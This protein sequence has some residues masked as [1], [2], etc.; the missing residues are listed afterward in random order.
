LYHCVVISRRTRW[1]REKCILLSFLK[2][3]TDLTVKKEEV[4]AEMK[5]Q[6]VVNIENMSVKDSS[7]GRRSTNTFVVTFRLPTLP[8]H[9]IV[10]YMRVPVNLYIESP[11]LFQVPKIWLWQQS[12]QGD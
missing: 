7:G 3:H 4:L 5:S 10:G 12:M 2:I 1:A 11:S 6:G 9:V 8:K